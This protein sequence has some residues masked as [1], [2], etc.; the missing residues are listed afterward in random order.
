M[1]LWI[2]SDL[3]REIR[4]PSELPPPETWPEHDIVVL[5]G[6]IDNSPNK[7]ITWIAQTFSKP[8]IYVMGNHEF[9]GRTYLEEMRLARSVCMSFPNVHLLENDFVDIGSTRIFGCTLWTDFA[10]YGEADVPSA[11]YDARW[12]MND[13]K[14]I[15]YEKVPRTMPTR[16]KPTHARM[17]HSR[18]K[19]WL[20]RELPSR[21][22][23]K[24]VGIE[25]V[26]VVTHHAP[27]R[28]SIAKKNLG[29]PVGPCFVSHL[30]HLFERYA[31]DLWVHGH[32]HSAFDYNV[33]RTR[34][35]ENSHGYHGEQTDFRWDK[36]VEL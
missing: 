30:P 28:F 12:N 32:T 20:E 10:L 21:E 16:F 9:Y 27:H 6:D 24:P 1:K 23:P 5:A 3:H 36:V 8:A 25:K 15:A 11:M 18:S 17:L 2:L 7:A 22:E 13:F 33:E 19:A 26:V 31:I 35:V 4:P 14:Q 34:V 29:S